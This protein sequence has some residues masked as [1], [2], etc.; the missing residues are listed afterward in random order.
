MMTDGERLNWIRLARTIGIGP[1]SFF[2][3]ISTLKCFF[4]NRSSYKIF[5][6]GA[7]NRTGSAGLG[8]FM[9]KDCKRNSVQNNVFSGFYIV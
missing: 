5:Q 8:M 7:Q 6:A 1:V 4:Q 3:L 2:Q 9:I